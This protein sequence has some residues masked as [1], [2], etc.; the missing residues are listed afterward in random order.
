MDK[1]VLIAF[2][3][4]YPGL[5]ASPLFIFMGVLIFRN[6]LKDLFSKIPR[7]PNDEIGLSQDGITF[8]KNKKQIKEKK[9]DK[10]NND[11]V[12]M[13]LERE[14]AIKEQASLSIQHLSKVEIE[15]KDKLLESQNWANL[16]ES[17]LN[18]YEFK[19][20]DGF[21]VNK[22]KAFL[23][24][25]NQDGFDM[26]ITSIKQSSSEFFS[27]FENIPDN[28]EIDTIIEVLEFHAL[29]N[30]EGDKLTITIR[31]QAYLAHLLESY[32][33]ELAVSN[34]TPHPNSS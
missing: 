22:T 21:L 15:L 18:L 4:V 1:E 16:L 33:K 7:F 13:F 34:T 3:N 26:G 24:K 6:E 32:E 25:I 23:I 30:I 17:R 12:K 19:Y 10:A 31:G 2:F 8:K 29:L 11:V 5:F 14:D 27:G 20:L 9:L 28:K